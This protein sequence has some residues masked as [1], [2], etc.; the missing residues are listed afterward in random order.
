MTVFT[1]LLY[2]TLHL[3]SLS[4]EVEPGGADGGKLGARL[5]VDQDMTAGAA[6]WALYPQHG[7]DWRR[8]MVS[9][10]SL[11]GCF[12]R[13]VIQLCDAHVALDVSL[14]TRVA[15][16]LTMR[17]ACI[18]RSPGLPAESLTVRS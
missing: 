18:G 17:L 2:G 15:L 6:T 7:G 12:L 5:M 9:Y 1:R 11:L 10:P 8:V 13:N 16:C 3:T 4:P 14:H